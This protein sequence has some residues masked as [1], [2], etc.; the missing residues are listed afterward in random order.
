MTK[1]LT[2]SKLFYSL[3]HSF[4]TYKAKRLC[5]LVINVYPVSKRI[6]D[7]AIGKIQKEN[8]YN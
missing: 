5:L 1:Y 4:F 3:D 2:L 7:A 6:K 8:C